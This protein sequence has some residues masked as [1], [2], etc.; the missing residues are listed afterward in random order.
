MTYSSRK[1]KTNE[2]KKKSEP[3]LFGRFIG[4][5]IKPGNQVKYNLAYVGQNKA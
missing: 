1:S 4:T 2:P 5:F 3:G